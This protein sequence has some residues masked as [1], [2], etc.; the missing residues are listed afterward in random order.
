[1]ILTVT[2]NPLVERRFEYNSV[3]YGTG[4]RNGTESVNAG[5]KGI[6][7]SRQL[8]ILGIDTMAY[9]FTGGITGKLLK[10]ILSEEIIKSSFV[11]TNHETRNCSVVVDKN[12]GSI[13]TYFGENSKI[14]ESES[15]EFLSRLEK[16]IQNCELVVFSG[17][18]PSEETNH[19]FKAGIEIA[20]KLD[21]ISVLDTYGKHHKEC[22]KASP[23]I[24][25]NNLDEIQNTFNISGETE[26]YSLMNEFYSYGIKQSYITNG[27]LETLASNFD[28][29][30]KILNPAVSQKDST[31]SGDAFT[32]G[33]VYGWHNNLTFEETAIIA[34]CMGA[35][36]AAVYDTCKVNLPQA[37]IYRNSV[38]I[39]PVGKKMKTLDVT[40][41]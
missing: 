21:K 7:V 30:F 31:G 15:S 6:N 29:H 41:D 22:I 34:S 19:I 38:K 18:S 8:N 26:I 3:K 1:M 4:N 33:I 32:S 13:T 14:T 35:A 20:N 23:T 24:I 5:G 17:S 25:H 11:Q 9:T 40:P 28:F 27:P 39:I 36:N 10:K 12:T 2:L 16:M 37:E